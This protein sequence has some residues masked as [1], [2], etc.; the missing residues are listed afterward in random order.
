MPKLS[1]GRAWSGAP[2]VLLLPG[3]PSKEDVAEHRMWPH[4]PAAAPP[5]ADGGQESEQLYLSLVEL[6]TNLRKV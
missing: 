1:R 6:E 4:P 5:P 2:P 3:V